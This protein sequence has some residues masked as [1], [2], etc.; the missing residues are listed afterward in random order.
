MDNRSL[1]KKGRHGDTHI[2]DVYG[3]KSHVNKLEA[4]IIDSYGFLG[5]EIV[6]ETGAGTINPKTGM[7]EYHQAM[8]HGDEHT[9]GTKKGGLF[10][11][12]T[13][14]DYTIEIPTDGVDGS[15]WQGGND[16][17]LEERLSEKAEEEGDPREYGLESLD[18]SQFFEAD[19]VT[20]KP[21]NQIVDL[22][23]Q[24]KPKPDN[25]D[26]LRANNHTD[27]A[28]QEQYSE[29]ILAKV[30]DFFPK[31][32]AI[33]GEEEG[34]LTK[35]KEFAERGAEI[36]RKS[37]MYGL[38]KQAGAMGSQMRSPYGGGSMGMRGVIGGQANMKYGA[39]LASD[40]YGLGMEKAAFAEEKG[41]YGL[42]QKKAWEFEG[43][44]GTFL[45]NFK[46]G[47]R[48]P[49]NKRQTFS[50][51]LSRIPDAGGT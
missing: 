16:L 42:K 3:L 9:H 41:V 6:K 30:Q 22:I 15:V 51:V 23:K 19:G 47:G 31:L 14:P 49:S 33:S 46:Q 40:K 27:A 20:P 50:Q 24:H 17:P 44:V 43:D 18:K 10:N 35:E 5:E 34:F 32:Q 25:Y 36:G 1:A 38:Q 4:D 2:R 26:Q 37:D 28:I 21:I 29:D 11:L 13:I 39:G 12:E 45:E 8:P 7:P 48:V